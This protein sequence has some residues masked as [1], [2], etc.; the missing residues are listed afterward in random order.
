[1]L[2]FCHSH[3]QLIPDVLGS[4]HQQLTTLHMFTFAHLSH[5]HTSEY[6]QFVC[7]CGHLNEKT[8]SEISNIRHFCNERKHLFFELLEFWRFGSKP[9]ITG[10][11]SR[12][13]ESA[14]TLVSLEFTSLCWPGSLIHR[15]NAVDLSYLHQR[16]ERYS[17]PHRSLLIWFE[18]GWIET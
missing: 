10:E 13:T 3:L 8:D 2:V 14:H 11:G 4:P 18:T 1:M 15:K 16:E 9:S 5:Y 17:F 6:I 12:E 7:K